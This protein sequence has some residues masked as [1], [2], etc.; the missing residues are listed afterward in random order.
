MMD[1]L[2]NIFP[3]RGALGSHLAKGISGSDRGLVTALEF[4]GLVVQGLARF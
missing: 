3:E 2:Q 4:C 1:W